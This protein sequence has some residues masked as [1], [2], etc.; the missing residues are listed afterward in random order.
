MYVRN[1]EDFL[2]CLDR[3]QEVSQLEVFAH[4][5]QHLIAAVDDLGFNTFDGQDYEVMGRLWTALSSR[6]TDAAL[7]GRV[8]IALWNCNNFG[9]PYWAELVARDTT[10]IRYAIEA[11]YWVFRVSRAD[12]GRAL[13]AILNHCACWDV[14]ERFVPRAKADLQQVWWQR[15]VMPH[16][17]KLW[18]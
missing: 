15:S 7:W 14:A 17:K 18:Y 6:D 16:R 1:R 5:R 12:G 2:A 11:A 4:A 8:C 13:A 3:D 9:G 10:N